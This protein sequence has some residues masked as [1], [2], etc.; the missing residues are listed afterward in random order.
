[1]I[2]TS[3]RLFRSMLVAGD[4]LA[5]TVTYVVADMLRCRLERGVPWPEHI[6]GQDNVMP[7]HFWMLAV[8][9]LLWPAILWWHDWYEAR[10][11]S[12]WWLLRRG[13]GATIL[14]TLFMAALALAFQ[15]ELYPR[16]QLGFTA[17]LLPA[18]TLAARSISELIGQWWGTRQSRHVLIVGTDR[19]AVRLRRLLRTVA[20]GKPVVM[21]H[22]RMP[23][24]AADHDQ[25][26]AVLGGVEKLGEILEKNVVDEVIFAAPL[27]QLPRMMP[28]IALCE[29]V[30]VTAA[31]LA[32][33]V[34]CHTP[35]AVVN[36]H[37][38]P[39]LTYSGARHPPEL[40]LVKRLFD[41][42]LALVA[43]A[44]LWPVMLAVAIMIR[45]GSGSPVLFRQVRSGLGGRPFTMLKFRTMHVDAESQRESVEHLN[46][47]DGPVFKAEADPRVTGVGAWL[48]RFS[49]DELPQLINVLRGDMA[50]VGPRP[51][52]PDEVE[53]YDRWQRRRLSMRPGLTCLW[54]IKGRHRIGFQ[55]W[56][57]LDLF[58][59]D[60]WSLKLD[61]LILGRTV[62]AVLSGSGA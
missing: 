53:Q 5:I 62:V 17:I 20:L 39:L 24:V 6:P 23:D 44:V 61:F 18:T 50:N 4:A 31:L 54:Q 7:V 59:I 26:G 15:R 25:T 30:G 51:P 27:E 41:L 56:M 8:L 42:V 55:E 57:Q 9:P 21:G 16:W 35:P 45:V 43:L 32:S 48:R 60:H 3:W 29:E 58:Y 40:L 33:S 49:L 52:L 28:Y 46:A 38:V 13:I 19:N 1:M 10:W 36:F 11:R 47:A 14:L 12:T 22:L 37:G 34:T 2:S